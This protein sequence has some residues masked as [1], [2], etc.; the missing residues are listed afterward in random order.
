MKDYQVELVSSD[1]NILQIRVRAKDRSDASVVA[2]D[3]V[4]ELGWQNYGYIVSQIKEI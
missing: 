1:R 4:K 3:R 2:M